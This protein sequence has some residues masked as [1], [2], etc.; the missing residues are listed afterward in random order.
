MT[1][2]Q[3]QG[4]SQSTSPQAQQD[5]QSTSQ[6]QA[7]QATVEIAK[8]IKSNLEQ[9]GF[10]N[11]KLVPSAFIVRAVDQNNNPVVMLVNPG[12]ITKVGGSKDQNT[13]GQ[14]PGASSS[15]DSD[16]AN[17]NDTANGSAQPGH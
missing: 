4:G 5:S 14:G 6:A 15:N 7:Q 16:Q 1:A 8:Q 9:A 13:I 10:K 12:S 3:V 17:G 2:P 11:I